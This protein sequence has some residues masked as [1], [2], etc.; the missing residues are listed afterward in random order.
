[1]NDD[2]DA[3]TLP[4]LVLKDKKI[5]IYAAS[6]IPKKGVEPYSVR[7]YAGALKELGWKKCI[8]QSDGELSLVALKQAASDA[9]PALEC[10]P[11]ESPVGDH[12]ANGDAESA[13]RE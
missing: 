1:M 6:A 12:A 2:V 3:N 5:K 4:M 9:L 11:R 10:I 7:F 8:L 13:V